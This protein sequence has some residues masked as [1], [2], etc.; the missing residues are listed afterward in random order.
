MAAQLPRYRYLNRDGV[1][2]D[3]R[4]HGLT[5]DEEGGLRLDS[6]PRLE[7]APPI[8]LHVLP[9]PTGPAGV[10]ETPEGALYFTDPECH[11]LYWMDTCASFPTPKPCTGGPGDMPGGLQSPRGVAYHPGLHAVLVVDAGNHRICLLDPDSHQVRGSWGGF[12][13]VALP[14]V[15]ESLDSAE[16]CD[17]EASS[18]SDGILE[19]GEPPD[20][21][22][23]CPD[24][25]LGPA[26]A[27]RSG[28]L[29]SPS[30]LAVDG[31]GNVYVADTAN[32][33]IQKFD[34]HGR[35]DAAFA[36]ASEHAAP[37]LG[38][39]T[40]VAVRDVGDRTDVFA[41]DAERRRIV[42][43]DGAGDLRGEIGDG[44]LGEP[45]GIAVAEDALYV[46]DN[47]HRP[48]GVERDGPGESVRRIL[49]FKCA[50]SGTSGSDRWTFVGPAAG[51]TGPISALMLDARGGL[52]VHP[53]A[54]AAQGCDSRG[55]PAPV[56]LLAVDGAAT[57]GFAV[58]GPFR[59]PSHRLEQWH[60]LEAMLDSSTPDAHVR[61]F[62]GRSEPPLV[63][64]ATEPPWCET[65]GAGCR[66]WRRPGLDSG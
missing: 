66:G 37:E 21:L 49:R 7:A 20:A 10:A 35:V 41:L 36:A 54:P 57:H 53:G 19:E 3:F 24:S 18:D 59:N 9:T 16:Q 39:V 56:R 32:R 38:L 31:A 11:L 65:N 50:S 26:K 5:V 13:A 29:A 60:R 34:M 25:R 30:D 61:L 58:G 22:V 33:R 55:M 63:D 42:V 1:W 64:G 15:D 45:M 2:A 40:G 6:V 17:D 62:V 27:P 46:G 14:A 51:Y 23:K 28:G 47:D 12:D 4:L 48:A 43:M 52:W 8:G 44:L